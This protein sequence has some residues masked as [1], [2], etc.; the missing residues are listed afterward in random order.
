MF[1]R[2]EKF[3]LLHLLSHERKNE[4]STLLGIKIE[5]ILNLGLCIKKTKNFL[6][7]EKFFNYYEVQ[8]LLVFTDFLETILYVASILFYCS[9]LDM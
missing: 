5:L 8:I 4:N 6:I 3:G 9:S 7:F 2:E 1:I